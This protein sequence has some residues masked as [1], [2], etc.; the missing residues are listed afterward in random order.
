[1]ST[2]KISENASINQSDA[3]LTYRVATLQDCESLSL[4]IN[5][6]YRGESSCQGWTTED[7]LVGG[8]R[9]DI[10]MLTDVINDHKNVILVFFDRTDQT[11]IGCVQ[12]QHKPEVKSA[13][14]RMLTV[15]P[16]LQGQGYG[17][18]IMSVAENYA[19]NNWNVEYVEMTVIIQ[20]SELIAYYNRRGYVDTGL[21]K[22]FPS[23]DIK[24]GIPKR[25]DLEFC[26]MQ[27]CFKKP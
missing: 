5:S 4:L 23:H 3:P 19:V 12:L 17:K 26:V 22:P 13:Y 24:F 2:T 15:R 9:V 21:R 10:Q 11:L 8:Q 7:S 1:M 18:F 20:R 16:N 6:A 25:N 27:K 14:L